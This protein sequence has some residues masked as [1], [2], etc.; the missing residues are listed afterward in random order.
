MTNSYVN[1]YIHIWLLEN[2]TTRI[3]IVDRNMYPYLL[4]YEQTSVPKMN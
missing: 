1:D 2:Y 3:L 4:L